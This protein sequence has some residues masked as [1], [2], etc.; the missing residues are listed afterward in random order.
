MRHWLQARA[1]EE[2]TRQEE[3]RTRQ[4]GL[5]LE[6]RKIE[7]DMLRSSLGGGVPPPMI[8][9]VFAGMASGGVLPQAALDWAQQFMASQSQYPQLPPPPRPQSPE[10][11]EAAPHVQYHASHAPSSS[12]GSGGYAPYGTSPT[13]ARGQTVS[14]P[15]GRPTGG[16]NI[17]SAGSN[18]PQSGHGLQPSTSTIGPFQAGAGQSGQHDSNPSI[19]FHH[20]QPPS[21]Q[22]GQASAGGSN[23]P[24]SPAGKLYSNVLTGWYR[25]LN[26]IRR[27][28]EEAQGWSRC[29]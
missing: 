25:M 18:T 26:C 24:N 16:S 11:R 27:A 15:M 14:G 23:R 21:S 10:A 20:W 4:E 13:R 8:P 9:L 5:R 19:Y 7:M 1:E 3:E 6:Q 22:A 29:S 28:S 2:K 12:H 17:S